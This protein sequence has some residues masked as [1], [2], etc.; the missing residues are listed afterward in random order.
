[1]QEETINDLLETLNKLETEEKDPLMAIICIEK[2]MK[3]Y[4]KNDQQYIQLCDKLLYWEIYMDKYYKRTM[5]EHEVLAEK[6]IEG[7]EFR[8]DD[9]KEKAAFYLERAI[10]DYK[11]YIEGLKQAYKDTIEEVRKNGFSY[12]IGTNKFFDKL[13]AANEK[14]ENCCKLYTELTGRELSYE[15]K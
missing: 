5:Y 3:M 9:D 6:L 7:Y 2:L 12:G 13:D 4:D 8:K 10:E 14:I 11:L 15:Y 1:M